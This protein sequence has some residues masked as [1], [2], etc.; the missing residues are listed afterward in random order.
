[1]VVG[2]MR[3]TAAKTKLNECDKSRKLACHNFFFDDFSTA[4][5]MGLL[6]SHFT[7]EELHLLYH[8]LFDTNSTFDLTFGPVLGISQD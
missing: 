1:M 5:F 2:T 6:N 7:L 3:F 4:I 8:Q